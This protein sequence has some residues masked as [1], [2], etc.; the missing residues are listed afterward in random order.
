MFACQ[1]QP[2][3]VMGGLLQRVL[4]QG[5]RDVLCNG[6]YGMLTFPVILSNW[7]EGCAL[8]TG[9]MSFKGLVNLESEIGCVSSLSC[10]PVEH[11]Y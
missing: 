1:R 4:S 10:Y 3:Q 7:E 5:N 6:L 9:K 8:L 11:G 2:L